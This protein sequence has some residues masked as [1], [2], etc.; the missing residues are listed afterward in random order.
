MSETN[1]TESVPTRGKRGRWSWRSAVITCLCLTMVAAGFVLYVL[2]SGVTDLDIRLSRLEAQD[3]TATT[4]ETLSTLQSRISTLQAGLADN[5]QRVETLQKAAEARTGPSQELASL[6]ESAERLQ[7]AQQEM[8]TRL[9]ALAQQLNALKAIPA[10]ATPAPEK[11]A[12][13]VKK[14]L[15]VKPRPTTVVTRQAPFVLTGVERRGAES[16]AAVA[17]RGY[18]S[19]SQIALIGEGETVSGWTLVRAGY[20]EATFRVNGRLTALRVE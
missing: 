14:P 3:N 11:T 10:A 19:L 15:P 5:Q 1:I 17:P 9:K 18:H 4:T 12:T 6:Q 8:E 13:E 2:V 20:S 16:W 7:Q